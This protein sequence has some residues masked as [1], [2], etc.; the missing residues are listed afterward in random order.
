M[1][2]KNARKEDTNQ[3]SFIISY[4]QQPVNK[5]SLQISGMSFLKGS[6][7][8]TIKVPSRLKEKACCD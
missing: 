5:N 3:K 8:I 7:V 4:G 2:I 6:H 1:I